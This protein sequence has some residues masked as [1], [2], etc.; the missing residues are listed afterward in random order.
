[1]RLVSRGSDLHRANFVIDNPQTGET[2]NHWR[3]LSSAYE[4]FVNTRTT[5]NK[6]WFTSPAW[7]LGSRHILFESDNL[8]DFR[9]ENLLT[10]YPELLI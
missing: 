9:Y 4:H 6:G 10:N 8:E 5:S 1:M 2:P 3:P 7:G